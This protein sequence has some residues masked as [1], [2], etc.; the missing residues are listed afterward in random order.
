MGVLDRDPR[1]QRIHD[2]DCPT[3]LAGYRVLTGADPVNDD[4]ACPVVGL[5]AG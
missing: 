4:V 5:G 1:F 3:M 2:R